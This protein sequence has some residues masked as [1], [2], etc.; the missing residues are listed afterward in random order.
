MKIDQLRIG[1]SM[2]VAGVPGLYLPGQP[3][4]FGLKVL[5]QA[6]TKAENWL[7]RHVPN[8]YAFHPVTKARRKLPRGRVR[9][10]EYER[11]YLPGYAFARFPG[12]PVW[13]RLFDRC[14]FI[15]DVI[16][17]HDGTPARLN[18][19]DLTRLHAMRSVDEDNTSRKRYARTI[20]KGDR[21]NLNLAGHAFENIEVVSL[22]GVFG[23]VR[24]GLL[25]KGEVKVSLEQMEKIDSVAS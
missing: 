10:V 3:A 22:D 13:H 25:G 15:H 18:P 7:K 1:D 17:Y 5:P 9:W 19:N 20:R 12:D 24:I 6:E 8:C 4:W 2:P 11:R 14:P 16:R 21:V 23:M